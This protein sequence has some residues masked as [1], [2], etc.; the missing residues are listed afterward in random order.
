MTSG[1]Q[2]GDLIIVAGRPS[3]GKTALAL[4][5]GEHVAV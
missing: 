3:M 4:N 5:I 1:M 2:P